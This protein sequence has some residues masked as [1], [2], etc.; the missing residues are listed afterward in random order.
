MNNT[1]C[2]YCEYLSKRP[3]S[4]NYFIYKCSYWGIVS[5]QILPQTAILNSIGKKCPFFKVKNKIKK[6]TE[7]NNK[8][9]NNNN[10]DIIA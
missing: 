6:D 3:G 5:Q 8:P 9:D 4:G 10:L 1:N 2:N 7:K